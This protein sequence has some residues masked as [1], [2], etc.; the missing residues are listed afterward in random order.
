M[1]NWFRKKIVTEQT[2]SPDG[3]E[4]QITPTS[5][6]DLPMI[7][8]ETT[9]S[10][11]KLQLF[12]VKDGEVWIINTSRN[13]IISE[14]ILMGLNHFLTPIETYNVG[15]QYKLISITQNKNLNSQCTVEE[16]MLK[17]MGMFYWF[18]LYNPSR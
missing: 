15:L 1:L 9:N 17:N 7:S 6:L 8:H 12:I 5:P 18:L 2:N 13:Q 10:K 4:I 11:D 16:E 14:L 3:S